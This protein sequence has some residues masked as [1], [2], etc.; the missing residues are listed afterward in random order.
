MTPGMVTMCVCVCVRRDT[1]CRQP[2]LEV[3]KL[4]STRSN[5]YFVNNNGEAVLRA[6][7]E[8]LGYIVLPPPTVGEVAELMHMV[9]EMRL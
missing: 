4:L 8:R 1:R 7:C 2:M 9:N 6:A 5:K 3:Q